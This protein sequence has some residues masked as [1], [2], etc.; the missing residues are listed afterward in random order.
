LAPAGHKRIRSR[1]PRTQAVVP[2]ATGQ[3]TDR[4]ARDGPS[5]RVD[6]DVD[7]AGS[8]PGKPV[9]K[10]LALEVD[11]ADLAQSA[12]GGGSG[13]LRRASGR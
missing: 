5:E 13:L 12:V 3:A 1:T 2:A 7:A 10:A 11:D 6:D 8:E 9:G 4:L